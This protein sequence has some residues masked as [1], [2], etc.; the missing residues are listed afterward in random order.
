MPSFLNYVF[1]QNTNPQYIKKLLSDRKYPE[2]QECPVY[3]NT[4]L[5]LE[6]RINAVNVFRKD[7][8]PRS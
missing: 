1:W 5:T 4:N 8:H 2:E 7:T 3:V 6:E